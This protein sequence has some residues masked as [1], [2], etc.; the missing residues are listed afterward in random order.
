MAPRPRSDVDLYED[1]RV[2]TEIRLK[3]VRTRQPFT[4]DHDVALKMADPDGEIHDAGLM[5]EYPVG[6]GVWTGS[7]VVDAPGE[8]TSIVE[9][10][11]PSEAVFERKF[12]VKA[13]TS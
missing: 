2:V 6:E 7:Y 1:T 4:G 5:V 8:W 9:V 12:Y 13:R 11:A 3:N 10:P